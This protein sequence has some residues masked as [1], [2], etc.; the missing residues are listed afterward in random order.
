MKKY[1]NIKDYFTLIIWNLDSDGATGIPA[2]WSW[3]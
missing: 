1:G 2:P 3:L